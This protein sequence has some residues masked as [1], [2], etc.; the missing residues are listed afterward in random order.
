MWTAAARPGVGP[1]PSGW[2]EDGLESYGVDAL[3]LASKGRG[4]ADGKPYPA[5]EASWWETGLMSAE[6]WQGKWIGYEE[7]EER[8]IRESG[9]AWITNAPEDYKGA[10]P[11]K[12]DFR[13]GF[14][15]AQP[16]KRAVLYVTGEDAAA[17]WVNGKQ[18]VQALP[19]PP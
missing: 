10:S 19:K 8:R 4:E 12:H 15:L 16:V 9:A 14:D 6:S 5:S 11:A 18:V 3:L 13:F 2:L 1:R 17:A 7:E